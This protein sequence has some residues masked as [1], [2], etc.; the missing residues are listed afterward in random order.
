M[1]GRSVLYIVLTSNAK[2]ELFATLLFLYCHVM[3][4]LATCRPKN[5][6]VHAQTI[7]NSLLPDFFFYAARRQLISLATQHHIER[8]VYACPLY[9]LW[10]TNYRLQRSS[11][12]EAS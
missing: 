8:C 7:G 12:C 5:W 11:T 9:Y 10:C 6:C 3:A 1:P 2:G 4:Q